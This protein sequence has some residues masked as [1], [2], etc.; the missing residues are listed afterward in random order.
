MH[1]VAGACRLQM[2]Y[3]FLHQYIGNLE[4]AL[5]TPACHVRAADHSVVR[6]KWFV[7]GLF[8]QR[9]EFLVGQYIEAR[10]QHP[11]VIQGIQYGGNVHDFAARAVEEKEGFAE[12]SEERRVG[13]ECVST[14]RSRWWPDH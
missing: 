14:C 1:L 13:K 5:Y 6:H 2:G 4:I 3:H 7:P 8:A 10:P 11:S 9:R 12:R